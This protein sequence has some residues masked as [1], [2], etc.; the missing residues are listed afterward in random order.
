MDEKIDQ[1]VELRRQSFLLI[2]GGRSGY[3]RCSVRN[4]ILPPPEFR[5]EICILSHCPRLSL[6][7]TGFGPYRRIR[8]DC[9]GTTMGNV[10]KQ[11]AL[12]FVLFLGVVGMLAAARYPLFRICSRAISG[13]L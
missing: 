4:F 13:L 6:Y 8:D 9:G 1:R 12:F 7:G 5:T 3:E 10:M 11:A 2:P